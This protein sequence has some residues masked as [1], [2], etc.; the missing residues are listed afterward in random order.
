MG[1]ILVSIGLCRLYHRRGDIERAERR[2]K[3]ALSC[4]EQAGFRRAVVLAREELG[5]LAFTRCAFAEAR[6]H[7]ERALEEARVVAATGDLVYEAAWRL[8]RVLLIEGRRDEAEELSRTALSLAEAA[9]D[10]REAGNARATLALV[11]ADA[12]D[13]RGALALLDE[14]VDVFREIRAPIELADT[15]VLRARIARTQAPAEAEKH[16]REAARIV[17]ELGAAERLQRI[18]LELRASGRDVAVAGASDA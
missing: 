11:L 13:L 10:R 18:E 2:A 12:G 7:Y 3:E 5:D 9:G 15:L 17:R 4:A 8:A 6:T 16:L 14:S 1:A